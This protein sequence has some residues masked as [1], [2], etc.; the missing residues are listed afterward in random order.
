[1]SRSNSGLALRILALMHRMCPVRAVAVQLVRLLACSVC[2]DDRAD[3]VPRQRLRDVAWLEAVDDLDLLDVLGR[4]QDLQDDPVDRQR[5]QAPRREL[6]GPDPG[7]ELGGGVVL[8]IGGV[9]PVDVVDVDEAG[10]PV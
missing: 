10:G 5:L 3:V 6:P 4:A 8:G 7:A 2:V 9:Y 1:M